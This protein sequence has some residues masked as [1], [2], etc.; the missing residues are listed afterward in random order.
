MAGCWTVVHWML[1]GIA[2][3]QF[4][5]D[6]WPNTAGVTSIKIQALIARPPFFTIL[7]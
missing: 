7:S 3:E 1:F 4:V 2:E 5:Y 6:V